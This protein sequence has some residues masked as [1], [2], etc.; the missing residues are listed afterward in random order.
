MGLFSRKKQ[1]FVSSS[2]WNMAGDIKKRSNFLKTTV[3]GNIV[4]DSGKGMGEAISSSYLTGPG[5]GLRR[6]AKWARGPSNYNNDVGYVSGGVTMGDSMDITKLTPFLDIPPNHTLMVNESDIGL[7]DS[8]W[9]AEEHMLTNHLPLLFTDWSSEYLEATGMVEITFEDLSKAQFTPA[10]FEFDKRYLYCLYQTVG[11]GTIGTIT[12]GPVVVVADA[13][14]Y[15]PLDPTLTYDKEW[16]EKTPST[17]ETRTQI[18]VTYTDGTPATNSDVTAPAPIDLI[19]N[20]RL[21]QRYELIDAASSTRHVH[22][23]IRKE[24]V[25]IDEWD[26]PV[27][28][29]VVE[30]VKTTVTT[31]TKR[32]IVSDYTHQTDTQLVSNDNV[33][34][35]KYFRYKEGTGNSTLDAMFAASGTSGSFLPFIPVRINNRFVKEISPQLYSRTRRAYSKAM[36]G[37]SLDKL[38]RKIKTNGQLGDLDFIYAV[39]GTSLNAPEAT[40]KQ[41]MFRFF[42]KMASSSPTAGARFDEF[43]TK[44]AAAAASVEAYDLWAKEVGSKYDSD[45]RYGSGNTGSAQTPPPVVIPYPE[46]PVVSLDMRSTSTWMNFHMAVQMNGVR[47]LDGTGLLPGKKKGDI[48]F[49]SLGTKS[50]TKKFVN[51]YNQKYSGSRA[52]TNV[53]EIYRIYHQVSATGW[54]AI[55]LIGLVHKNHVYKGKWVEIKASAAFADPEESGFIIPLQEDTYREMSLVDG[56]QLASACCYLVFNCYKEVKKKWYQTGFFKILVVGVIIVISVVFA[57]AGTG[58]AGVLGSSAAVGGAMGLTGTAAIIAGTIANAIAAVIITKGMTALFGDTVG[59]ILGTVITMGLTVT[60]GLSGGMNFDMS[61]AMTELSK[62][63]NLLA[64]TDGLVKSVGAYMQDQNARIYAETERMMNKNRK[65]ILEV[66]EKYNKMFGGS[67]GIIDP[68]M[69][70][71]AG[72]FDAGETRGA[73]LER[74]LMCGSDIAELSQDL[75]RNFSDITL[76]LDLPV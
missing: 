1:L 39:Y 14:A 58:A 29:T 21:W 46:I 69:F 47:K 7:A 44:W 68:M 34:N 38:I 30:G 18:A 6:Y 74:T 49:E 25:K 12:P 50:F 59:T 24:K 19:T 54:E 9:W 61:S 76:N 64:I 60:G 16:D 48:W 36:A 53:V 2:V 4:S 5:M 57:P 22:L 73:Y 70:V 56:T 11:G 65:D 27:V 31:V 32:K 37:G 71:D 8:D 3:V 41:Y 51:Y 20:K 66:T 10:A 43:E 40:A 13:T 55:D 63:P 75:V 28:T 62:V 42:D 15:P 72:T 23:R 35:Y 33:S 17:I 45:D 26:T 67:K 52:D